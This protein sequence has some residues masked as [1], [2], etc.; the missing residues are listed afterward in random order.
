MVAE[1]RR[2][3]SGKRVVFREG[4]SAADEWTRRRRGGRSGAAAVSRKGRDDDYD[5]DDDCAVNFKTTDASSSSSS[6][7]FARH[8]NVLCYV[9]NLVGYLRMILVVV[10]FYFASSLSSTSRLPTLLMYFCSF[11]CDEL[12]GRFARRCNQ[13]SEFGAVLDM[14]TDRLA[15]TG[16]LVILANMYGGRAQFWC[17]ALIFLDISSHWFQMHSQLAIGK[18][19]HKDMVQSR[20]R[21]L[22]LYYAKRAFMGYCC[23]STEILYLC[24]YMMKDGAGTLRRVPGIFPLERTFVGKTKALTTV[25]SWLTRR[26]GLASADAFATQFLFFAVPGFILK[27]VANVAQLRSAVRSMCAHEPEFEK[28]RR[29]GVSGA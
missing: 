22:R 26:V 13:C 27:Q 6:F 5:D 1:T 23:I 18:K 25:D 8:S 4:K 21:L 15:T 17:I 10:A 16:L 7:F 12:D 11:V 28:K 20:F 3:G 14:V 19:G 9:P 2:R 29:R 24:M